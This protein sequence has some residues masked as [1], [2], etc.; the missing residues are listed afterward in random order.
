MIGRIFRIQ[1]QVKMEPDERDVA[2]QG[3]HAHYR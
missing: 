3:G 2:G 1:A